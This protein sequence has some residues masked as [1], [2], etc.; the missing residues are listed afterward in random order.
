[1]LVGDVMSRVVVKVSP[2]TTIDHAARLMLHHNIGSV[3]VLESGR[4]VGILTD[5]D[6]VIR[7]IAEN[8]DSI[9]SRVSDLM[10]RIVYSCSPNDD[11]LLAAEKFARYQVRRLP[12][13]D[14]ENR[15]VGMLALADLAIND[16]NAAIFALSEICESEAFLE[17]TPAVLQ[18]ASRKSAVGEKPG[19]RSKLRVR[20]PYTSPGGR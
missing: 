2:L 6:I 12:V 15:L 11:L 13:V 5:R 17:E 20:F 3:P 14:D 9:F 4:L 19:P 10:T 7:G 18:G 16:R 8:K 1:M